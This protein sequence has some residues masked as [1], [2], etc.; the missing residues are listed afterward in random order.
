MKKKLNILFTLGLLY[1]LISGCAYDKSDQ[2][3]PKP[4]GCDTIDVS[5]KTDL[6]PIMEVNCFRC[7]SSTNAPIVGGNYNLQDYN[8]ISEAALNG[9]LLSS[10]RQDGILA[11]PMPADGGKLSDCDINK[12]AAWSREA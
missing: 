10:I 2:V 12:F 1:A 4:Q 7:H 11:P 9:K 6:T 8:T 3:Y 5:L